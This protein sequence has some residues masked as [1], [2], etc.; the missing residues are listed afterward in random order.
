VKEFQSVSV[1]SILIL[2]IVDVQDTDVLMEDEIFGPI[3]PFVR[4]ES[5]IEAL[6]YINA[7]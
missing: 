5:A 7:K 1:T 4:S 6:N 3:L 2:L